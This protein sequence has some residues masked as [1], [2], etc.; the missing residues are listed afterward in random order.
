MIDGEITEEGMQCGCSE[1]TV[2]AW[3]H[4]LA[5]EKISDSADRWMDGGWQ[6]KRW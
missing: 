5:D 6:R 2:G 3:M 4:C 1:A